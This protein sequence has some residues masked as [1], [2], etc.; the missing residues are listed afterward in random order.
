M[1]KDETI[2]IENLTIHAACNKANE[3]YIYFDV[4]F[5]GMKIGK[6]DFTESAMDK[7]V[8]L[9]EEKGIFEYE[10]EIK[11]KLI[12]IVKSIVNPKAYG[13][14]KNEM[15]FVKLSLVEDDLKNK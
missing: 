14:F 2:K 1:E 7:I 11:N 4:Y 3:N 12:S 8:K 5:A 13:K 15:G 10:E 6:I 9:H